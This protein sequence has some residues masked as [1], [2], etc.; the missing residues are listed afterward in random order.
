MKGPYFLIGALTSPLYIVVQMATQA[1]TAPPADPA[2]NE[3]QKLAILQ[4]LLSTTSIS[5]PPQPDQVY[6]KARAEPAMCLHALQV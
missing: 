5:A 1:M 4:A 6:H 3:E 2:T